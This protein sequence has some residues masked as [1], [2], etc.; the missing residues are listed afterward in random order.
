MMVNLSKTILPLQSDAPWRDVMD[1]KLFSVY[2]YAWGPLRP[3]DARGGHA[4][5]EGVDS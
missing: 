3:S 5:S 4:N 1:G 2:G